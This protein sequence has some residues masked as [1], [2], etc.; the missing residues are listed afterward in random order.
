MEQLRILI[1]DAQP[2]VKDGLGIFLEKDPGFSVIATTDS[3]AEGLKELRRQEVDLVILDLS[4]TEF[5]QE[6]AI[7]LFMAEMPE[8][9]IIVF[10]AQ[11]EE[12]SVFRA[13]KAGARGYI[14]KSSP[15]SDLI[16]AIHEVNRGGYIISPRLNPAIF[17]YY[18]KNRDNEFD[19]LSEYQHLSERE[20]QVFRLLAD[21]KQTRD[22][23]DLLFISPKTVAK[24]RAAV[25]K[26]LSLKNSAE[27][28]LYAIRLGLV[29]VETT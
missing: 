10:S 6:E 11:K 2:I 25:K 21:G 4:F 29:S 20:K 12:S 23:A 22:V 14:L 8:L 7:R 26:K 16:L 3:C 1:V 17:D 5:E 27:I 18:L 28:A 13:L 15:V 9:D 24:H 19:K